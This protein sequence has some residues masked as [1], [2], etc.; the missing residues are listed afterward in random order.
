[1]KQ[2]IEPELV[3]IFLG[4]LCK[5]NGQIQLPENSFEEIKY[6]GGGRDFEICILYK[7]HFLE[8]FVF[9][10]HITFISVMSI[11]LEKI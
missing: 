4:I 10:L 11:K 9:E 7:F 2:S 6:L 8:H 1:M 3:R 5:K